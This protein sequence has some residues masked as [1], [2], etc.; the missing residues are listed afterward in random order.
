MDKS[1]TILLMTKIWRWLL[2]LLGVYD[3]LLILYL[4]A[5][6]YLFSN[7]VFS[8][9]AFELIFFLE[10]LFYRSALIPVTFITPAIIAFAMATKEQNTLTR[11]IYIAAGLLFLIA[12]IFEFFL[13][14]LIAGRLVAHP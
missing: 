12:I 5:D 3:G 13:L 1:F 9:M 10:K 2:V 8:E 11:R 14:F 6:L 4:L 7:I